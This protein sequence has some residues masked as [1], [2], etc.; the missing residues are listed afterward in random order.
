MPGQVFNLPGWNCFPQYMAGEYAYCSR[1]TG[2]YIAISERD[3]RIR[4]LFISLPVRQ[5]PSLLD[6]LGRPPRFYHNHSTRYY[7]YE[8]VR[9]FVYGRFG[10]MGTTA[11]VSIR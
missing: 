1:Q 11:Y 9:V 3:G 4:T 8:H 2:N 6:S 10:R 7:E 5:L